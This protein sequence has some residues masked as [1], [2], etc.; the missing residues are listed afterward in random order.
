MALVHRNNDSRVCGAITITSATSTYIEGELVALDGDGNSHTGGNIIASGFSNVY[1]ENKKVSVKGDPAS[2]D[3][4]HPSPPTTTEGSADNTYV[5]WLFTFLNIL[6]L[7][8][9]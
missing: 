9:I 7:P 5:G 3:S 1:V 2:S 8:P 6:Q 4:F